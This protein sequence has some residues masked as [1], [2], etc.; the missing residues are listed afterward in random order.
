MSIL[1]TSLIEKVK[2]DLIHTISKKSGQGFSYVQC[3]LTKNNINNNS[4]KN[5]KPVTSRQNK[6]YE[7]ITQKL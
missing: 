6:H 4:A 5:H 3:K 1:L 7:N 2:N